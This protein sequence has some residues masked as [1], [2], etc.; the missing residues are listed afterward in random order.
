[1]GDVF[2]L[3]VEQR[4]PAQNAPRIIE[5]SLCTSPACFWVVLACTSFE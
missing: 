5:Q 4:T 1:L 3:L 2:I